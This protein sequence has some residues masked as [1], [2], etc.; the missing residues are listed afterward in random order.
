MAQLV[1]S[2]DEAI[3]QAALD[4]GV[5][6]AFAYPG[7]PSTEIMEYLQEHI[8]TATDSQRAAQW[9]ANEKTAYESALGVSYCGKRAMASM[10]HVGLNVAMD[11]FVN[12]A[13]LKIRGGLVV[14]VADDPSMHSSQN[15]QDSRILADFA[16]VP[17]FEPSDQQS[18]YEMMY[19]A[20]DYSEHNED[21][22]MLLITTRLAHPRAMVMTQPARHIPN[23]GK[24]KD[25][26]SWVLLPALA[27]K[28]W[29]VLLGK[30]PRF[31]A[32][33]EA[34]NQLDLQSK[35]LG[36]ITCGLARAYYL[37]NRDDWSKMHGGELP[38]HLHIGQ[39]PIG[40]DKIQ[41]L[42]A[43]VARILVIEEGYPFIEREIRGVFG[44]PVPVAG[45]LTGEIPREGE[46]SPDSVRAAL[47]LPLR[48]GLQ[49]A[50]V[51]V[52]GRPPQ[53][54]QGCPHADSFT[55][56]KKALEGQAD[57]FTASDIGCY[58][59]ESLPPWNAI[60]SCVDMGASAGMA[61]GAATVGQ[62]RAIGVIGD[63]TF[64]HSG[65]T[66]LLDAVQHH[67]PMVLIILDN[68]TTGMTGAQPSISPSE[69]LSLLLE[70]LGVEKAH[71]HVLEAHR[72]SIEANISIIRQELDYDGV[73][74][75]V[76][77]RECIEWLKKARQL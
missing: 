22:V 27:R 9:C 69:R 49:G 56:L 24:A 26:A 13:L 2:G 63:S 43:H 19:Q 67:T 7:T 62:K 4:A 57:F 51:E 77:L 42:A 12:S 68:G 59:L 21:P 48:E 23:L 52:P 70:G 40:T 30:Q 31:Q 37:E 72:R 60:E 10:K 14:V 55:A 8:G 65:M 74:V 54:C 6:G 25:T 76:M 16:Q 45:K 58:T 66:N 41:K 38:S 29:A 1:L 28:R 34:A 50:G 5:A 15:E 3:A 33:A 71:I 18:A 20:F 11:P 35:E 61:R 75:I 39:Y 73:S 64:Y 46:L 44:A 32:D 17:C 53:F 36:V 47:G